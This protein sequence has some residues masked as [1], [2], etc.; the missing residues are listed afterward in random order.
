MS[1]IDLLNHTSEDQ[2]LSTRQPNISSELNNDCT[3][4][5]LT[6]LTIKGNIVL[7]VLYSKVMIMEK[8][9]LQ[10]LYDEIAVKSFS[11]ELQSVEDFYI[12]DIERYV[13]AQDELAALAS[14]QEVMKIYIKLQNSEIN[15]LQKE[16]LKA[17]IGMI[18]SALSAFTYDEFDEDVKYMFINNMQL[19]SEIFKSMVEM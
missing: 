12:G 10:R 17:I 1:N 4:I 13:I 9:T 11:I 16:I 6:I 7:T 8:E 18:D 5:Y 2:E 15:S 14:L 3:L 19:F